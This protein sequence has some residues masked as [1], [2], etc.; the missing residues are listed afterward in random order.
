MGE[1]RVEQDGESGDGA[2]VASR[3]ARLERVTTSLAR[4]V[5]GQVHEVRTRRL[6]VTDADGNEV[7]VAE[8]VGATAELRV[9]IPGPDRGRRS[10]VVLFATGPGTGLGPGVGLQIWARGDEVVGLD[11]WPGDD[12]RWRAH[13]SLDGEP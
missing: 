1:R 11:A 2:T 8:T 4:A 9:E 3:L 10:A 6:V 13:L 12:R 7:V 5:A